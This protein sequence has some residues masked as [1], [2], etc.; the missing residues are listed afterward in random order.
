MHNISADET[1]VPSARFAVDL[2][3][4]FKFRISEG[5]RMLN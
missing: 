4:R 1:R 3:Y 2:M 5:Y